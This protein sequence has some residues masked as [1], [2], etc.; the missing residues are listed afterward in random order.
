MINV[1][2]RRCKCGAH[3]PCFNYPDEDT[4]LYCTECPGYDPD[5]MVDIV[6]RMCVTCKSRRPTFNVPG[7]KRADYCKACSTPDMV[8]VVTPRCQCGTHAPCFNYSDKEVPEF[9]TQ[10]P[11]FDKDM[12]DLANK[13]KQCQSP[14]GCTTR[15]Y[16]EFEGKM[17]CHEHYLV[18]DPNYI[19][20][21]VHLNQTE[22]LVYGKM[23]ESF[24]EANVTH[25]AKFDWCKNKT[26]LPFD[27]LVIQLKILVEVDGPQHDPEYNGRFGSGEE[28]HRVDQYKEQCARENGYTVVRINQP[29]VWKHKENPDRW[30]P[31][32]VE[33]IRAQ[34]P[35]R[36]NFT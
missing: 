13:N 23:L 11:G 21:G 35:A 5:K 29:F 4:A 30:L 9:C 17:Y 6:N 12:V 1:V 8:D 19:N 28:R 33:A 2:T 36:L 32:L 14:S 7:A 10:C 22:M 31:Q 18:H 15:A 27:M 25:Q 34:Q 16:F 3:G 24:G 20:K 26:F